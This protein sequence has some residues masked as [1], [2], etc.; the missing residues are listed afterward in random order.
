[1][2]HCDAMNGVA[3]LWECGLRKRPAKKKKT[4]VW[5]PRNCKCDQNELQNPYS[6]IHNFFACVK[7]SSEFHLSD[8]FH[9]TL[10]LRRVI[11]CVN[12]LVAESPKW[13]SGD[14]GP[15]GAWTPLPENNDLPNYP[16]RYRS[17]A[18]HAMQSALCVYGHEDRAPYTGP[19]SRTDASP[20]VFPLFYSC[21]ILCLLV[22]LSAL[23]HLACNRTAA[24]VAATAVPKVFLCVLATHSLRGASTR[25]SFSFHRYCCRRVVV[26]EFSTSRAAH[27][28]SPVEI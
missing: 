6:F 2:F 17:F 16:R 8:S 4:I 1:M 14:L 20:T 5:R 27:A 11:H 28:R 3:A 23:L 25:H 13:I 26:V 12:Q 22:E 9:L 10:T 7:R 15:T 18:S 19:I 24:T 21:F